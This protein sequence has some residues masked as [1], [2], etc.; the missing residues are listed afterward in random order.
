MHAVHSCLCY[1]VLTNIHQGSIDD[2]NFPWQYW[3]NIYAYLVDIWVWYIVE[4]K[5]IQLKWKITGPQNKTYIIIKQEK[6]NREVSFPYFLLFFSAS[7]Y[8]NKDLPDNQTKYSLVLK[9]VDWVYVHKNVQ[10]QNRLSWIE[11]N[12]SLNDFLLIMWHLFG[13]RKK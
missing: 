2:F 9:D 1:F 7:S 8:L 3:Q 6:S 5:K 10:K 11:K 13:R 12:D 4:H